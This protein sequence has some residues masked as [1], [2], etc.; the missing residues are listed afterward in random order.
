MSGYGIDVLTYVQLQAV[1]AKRRLCG[2][3]SEPCFCCGWALWRGRSIGTSLTSR[4]TSLSAV[5]AATA[6][7]T[8][9]KASRALSCAYFAHIAAFYWK[10]IQSLRIYDWHRGRRLEEFVHL[11]VW[12]SAFSGWRYTLVLGLGCKR[13]TWFI[14]L[15]LQLGLQIYDKYDSELWCPCLTT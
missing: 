10:R 15:H 14:Y 1:V 4:D 5:A 12:A 8:V 7:M 11:G 2:S 3:S 6:A 13:C 9:T